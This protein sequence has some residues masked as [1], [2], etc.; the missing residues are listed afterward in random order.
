MTIRKPNKIIHVKNW[1]FTELTNSSS[2]WTEKQ[3]IH[4]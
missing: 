2:S 4:S 1:Y 3:I